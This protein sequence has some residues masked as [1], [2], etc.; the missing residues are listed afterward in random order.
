MDE[1]KG[2]NDDD[3]FFKGRK[4]IVVILMLLL[5]IFL[6]ITCIFLL[7]KV[8][9][10]EVRLEEYRKQVEL[11][12]NRVMQEN[13]EILDGAID[14]ALP[15]ENKDVQDNISS[16]SQEQEKDENSEQNNSDSTDKEISESS[17]KK[18]YLTF[19]DGPSDN[20]E[21]ILS[22]LKKYDVK[23]TFFMTG[24]SAKKHPDLVK[25]IYDE[26]HTIGMH[27]YSH[28]YEEIYSSVKAFKEDYQKVY[29][30]LYEITGEAPKYYRFPGGSSNTIMDKNIRIFIEFLAFQRVEYIDWNAQN[31]DATNTVL[32][33]NELVD[34]ILTDVEK[35]NS[36]IVLMHDMGSKDNTVKS[37]PRLIKEL[38]KMDAEIL[39]IDEN[40]N[41]VKHVKSEINT[42]IFK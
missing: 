12:A 3:R 33:P 27:S 26:D 9:D 36:S 1:F 41:Y 13:I 5:L 37:L 11:K 17:T 8:K 35:Y 25:K 22:I 15:E 40:T 31:G 19:D 14:L 2:L 20:T 34:N 32:T 16:D 29:D 39:P 38:K 42:N 28:D 21:E 10:L 6:T 30:I 18:V 7:V 23:A 24:K 4:G